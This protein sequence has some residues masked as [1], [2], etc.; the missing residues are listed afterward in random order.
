VSV[1]WVT[2]GMELNAPY[3]THGLKNVPDRTERTDETARLRLTPK[4]RP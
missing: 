3:Y 4:G 1:S 2:C